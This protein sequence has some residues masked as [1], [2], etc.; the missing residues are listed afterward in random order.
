VVE[1]ERIDRPYEVR[2][3]LERAFAT[4]RPYVLDIR[5]DGSV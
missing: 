2:P 3:A 4:H 1:A 5:I